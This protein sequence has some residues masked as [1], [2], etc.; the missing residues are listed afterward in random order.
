MNST[1]EHI[2]KWIL[3][4]YFQKRLH[5]KISAASDTKIH[6]FHI[7]HIYFDSDVRA[8]FFLLARHTHTLTYK[9]KSFTRK[10]LAKLWLCRIASFS[11][12]RISFAL[13][14]S[15]N[16]LTTTTIIMLVASERWWWWCWGGGRRR[17]RLRRQTAA[18]RN[19]Q[20]RL[21][22][23]FCPICPS[24][25]IFYYFLLFFFPG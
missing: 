8:F 1:G 11:F 21:R 6:Y 4:I 14:Q 25:V 16:A 2:R 7:K 17:W 19:T 10:L 23:S 12:V 20:E 15:S 9:N 13:E 24:F 22:F 5:L 3:S 18:I